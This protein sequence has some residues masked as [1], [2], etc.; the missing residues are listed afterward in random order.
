MARFYDAGYNNGVRCILN[1]TAYD[2]EL[3][4]AALREDIQQW[5]REAPKG[6]NVGVNIDRQ[7]DE[8]IPRPTRGV[9]TFVPES[10]FEGESGEMMGHMWTGSN[11]SLKE[12]LLAGDHEIVEATGVSIYI[13][14]SNNVHIAGE[15]Q[16]Y[17][18]STRDLLTFF[19]CASEQTPGTA[20]KAA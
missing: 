14:F 18:V 3:R 7:V 5:L 20:E 16:D 4:R 10:F 19:F 1:Q 15:E 13:P 6:V 2:E 11:E 17:V 9:M 12:L 8:M